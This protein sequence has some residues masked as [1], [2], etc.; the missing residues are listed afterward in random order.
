MMIIMCHINDSCKLYFG[1][2]SIN[3]N[4][5]I[6][7]LISVIHLDRVKNINYSHEK[8]T[9]FAVITEKIYSLPFKYKKQK[10]YRNHN[11]I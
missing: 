10:P 3:D 1:I 11:K 9:Q 4:V 7:I 5:S 8:Y 2:S 6:A